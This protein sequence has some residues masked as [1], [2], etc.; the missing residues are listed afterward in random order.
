MAILK[1][2]SP[3][4]SFGVVGQASAKESAKNYVANYAGET[5]PPQAAPAVAAARVIADGGSAEA[6]ADIA[7]QT[8]CMVVTEGAGALACSYLTTDNIV[9]AQKTLVSLLP[10]SWQA[11]GVVQCWVY[12]HKIME[13]VA[14]T[15]SEL[16]ELVASSYDATR[17]AMGLPLQDLRRTGT[18]SMGR[19]GKNKY[20]VTE[21]PQ[22]VETFIKHPDWNKVLNSSYYPT[23]GSYCSAIPQA[24]CPA[25]ALK[26][27]GNPPLWYY[28]VSPKTCPSDGFEDF[29]KS[30]LRLYVVRLNAMRESVAPTLKKLTED[31]E[32]LLRPKVDFTSILLPEQREKKLVAMKL[33]KPK[34]DRVKIL[35]AIAVAAGV[36]AYLLW[37]RR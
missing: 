35:G 26:L 11:R 9:W 17:E 2:Y 25:K 29:N 28:A 8:A 15:Y 14:K 24:N 5:V 27:H 37:N 18:L 7:M 16:N 12:D 34:S 6:A 33:A 10:K 22:F 13:S 31:L 4:V 36:S 19:D 21:V 32:P 23:E 20:T 3:K 30:L 1:R